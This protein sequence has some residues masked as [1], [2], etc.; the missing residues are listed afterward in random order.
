MPLTVRHIETA[1]P[2]DKDYKLTDAQGLYLQVKK[3]SAKYWCLKYRFAGKEKN[4]HRSISRGHSSTG[5]LL[6]RRCLTDTG[7]R[8][9][10]FPRKA[11]QQTH[12]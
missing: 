2:A 1:K 8:Q 12:P 3:S 6:S 11:V 5:S 4:I 7:R 9:S 10:P